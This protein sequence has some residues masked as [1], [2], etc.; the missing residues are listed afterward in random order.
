M[1]MRELDPTS[2]GRV[3]GFS[4]DASEQPVELFALGLRQPRP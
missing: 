3:L 2:W 4:V 1:P